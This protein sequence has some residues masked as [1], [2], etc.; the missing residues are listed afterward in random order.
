MGEGYKK[1]VKKLLLIFIAVILAL[2]LLPVSAQVKYPNTLAI[3]HLEV[4]GNYLEPEDQ[5]YLITGT[6]DYNANPAYGDIRSTYISRLMNGATELGSSTF[7]N[8]YNDGYNPTITSAIYFPAATA[9][10]WAGAYTAEIVGNPL[11]QWMNT[12]ANAT[13]AS[14]VSYNATSG[15]YVDE[16]AA[17]NNATTNDIHPITENVSDAYY[18]GNTNM[19]STIKLYLSTNGNWAGSYVYEYWNGTDWITTDNTTDDTTGFTAGVGFHDISFIPSENWQKTTVNGGNY[20]WVRFRVTAFTS[21]TTRAMCSQGWND[22]ATS[23]PYISSSTWSLWYPTGGTGTIEAT[24]D[25]LTTRIR[26]LAQQTETAWGVD[27]INLVAGVYKLTPEGEA[28]FTDIIPSLRTACPDLF[29]ASVSTPTGFE[30]NNLVT[31]YNADPPDADYDVFGV[32]W[33]AQTWTTGVGYN[34]NG[35]QLRIYKAGAPVGQLT[36]SIRATAAGLPNGANLA[37]GNLTLTDVT[38]DT[39]GDWYTVSFDDDYE[40]GNDTQYSIVVSVPAG[41]AANYIAWLY[42]STGTLANGNTCSSVNSGVA[43]AAIAAGAHDANFVILAANSYSASYRNR[44][45]KQLVGTP[46]DMTALG[47]MLNTTRMWATGVV[48]FLGFCMPVTIGSCYAVKS[49]KPGFM[50]MA[51]IMLFGA[52]PGFLYLEVAI[53]L[54]VLLGGA[55]V[56]ALTFKSA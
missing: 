40:L 54:F 37:T 12:T 29:T 55:G 16:T 44:L 49:V 10:A 30:I 7:S 22:T 31:E 53:I 48:F 32:N 38:T 20:Y 51:F 36:A 50:I 47:T 9:P 21:L 45:A 2:P 15:L 46:F 56:W 39:L 24:K 33:Y 34:I 17:I 26:T 18:F 1:E 19:F 43:W 6:V 4:Y 11:L 28:Y 25:R 3:T 13:W 27:L 42:D 8:Y 41:N 14:A 23:P 5:L 35:V 52:L